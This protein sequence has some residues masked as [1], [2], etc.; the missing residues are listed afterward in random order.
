LA[1]EYEILF[2]GALEANESVTKNADGVYEL[3]SASAPL[4]D[5][6][7]SEKVVETVTD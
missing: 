4:P 3:A 7:P 1:A 5:V 6:P 2:Y